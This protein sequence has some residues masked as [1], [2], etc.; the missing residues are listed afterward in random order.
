MLGAGW[1]RRRRLVPEL[2]GD[3]PTKPGVGGRSERSLDSTLLP[4]L[5]LG[6]KLKPCEEMPP[7]LLPR[8]HQH[9]FQSPPDAEALA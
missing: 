8:G 1:E 7:L 6:G 4:F 5:C 2:E 3:T 9:S